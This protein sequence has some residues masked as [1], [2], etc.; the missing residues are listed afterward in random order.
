MGGSDEPREQQNFP[1]G[2]FVAF[3]G[4]RARSAQRPSKADKFTSRRPWYTFRRPTEIFA[5]GF[6]P[7]K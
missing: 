6:F 4:T 7:E 5:A 1:E 3:R 2:N